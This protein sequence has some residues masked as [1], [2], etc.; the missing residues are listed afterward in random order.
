[1]YKNL[2]TMSE[3][4]RG[5]NNISLGLTTDISIVG[6]LPSVGTADPPTDVWAN[7]GIYPFLTAAET[8]KIFSDSADDTVTGTGARVVQV[9][10]L[11]VNRDLL[12]EIV[13]LNGTTAVDTVG[14]FYRV[15]QIL[16]LTAGSGGDNAGTIVA[17]KG[18]DVGFPITF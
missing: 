6:L 9:T 5:D 7:G 12:E 10:G 1:V 2:K 11:D 17:T 8:L 4:V 13:V 18:T 14:E 16:C 3:F 15:N